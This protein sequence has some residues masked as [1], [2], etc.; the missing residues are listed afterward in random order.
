M[1]EVVVLAFSQ[2]RGPGSIM[3]VVLTP[4]E[5][6]S[7]TYKVRSASM[8]VQARPTVHAIIGGP[9]HRRPKCGTTIARLKHWPGGWES[10]TCT[11]CQRG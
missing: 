6:G 10:V 8:V 5:L 3:S 7:A 9:V 4:I 11:R 1:T 2:P